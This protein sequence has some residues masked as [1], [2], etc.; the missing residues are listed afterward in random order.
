MKILSAVVASLLAATV[1]HAGA[2][3]QAIIAAVKLAEAPN[4][5][6]STSV[7][8]DARS[9]VIEG[10]TNLA[11]KNDFSL[12]T[13]PMVATVRR[14]VTRATS[15]SENVMTAIFCGDERLLIQTPDGWRKPEQLSANSEGSA[16]SG[17]SGITSRRGRRGS[18]GFPGG[19]DRPAP[20][21]S[22]LQLTL[23]RPHEELAIIVAGYT[24]IKADGD[25]ISGTLSETAAK[26]LLV[27]SGQ[28]EITPLTAS[29]TFRFWLKD[30]ALVHYELKLEGTLAVVAN[31]DRHEITVHQ[32]AT[33]DVKN[34]GATTFDVPDE[35]KKK[36]GVA[37]DSSA[38]AAKAPST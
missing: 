1:A 20:A 33:T 2:T 7:D 25:V 8:D 11:D 16:R 9:Y 4:Y 14:R 17:E 31:G 13:M 12:V 22:N 21:Y 36:F 6:W 35:A 34:V 19:S 27:H 30:G 29:G 32:T 10:Q 23:S 15:N 26:L 28:K 38:P 18:G 37:V 24:D 5:A 3:D